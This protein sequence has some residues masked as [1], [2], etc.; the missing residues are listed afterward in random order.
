MIRK[1]LFFLLLCACTPSLHAQIQV[2]LSVK[3]RFFVVYEPIIAT[4]TITN[5][6]GRDVP[7]TDADS[8]HW[9][10]FEIVRG[11]GE[12]IAPI[13]PNY[14]MSPLVIPAGQTVKRSVNLN[15]L[16][17]VHDFGLH[18]IKAAIYFAPMQKYFV[19][20]QVNIELS[21]GKVIWQQ[22]VGVPDGVKGAGGT[23]KMSLL[24]F[25]QDDKNILYV[26]VEDAN[27]GTIYCT[28]PVGALINET[29]PQIQIDFN[30]QLHLL[31]V[32][33]PKT[34]AYS[35][36]GTNGEWL[37]QD[38]YVSTKTR[39]TLRRDGASEVSVVGGELRANAPAGTGPGSATGGTVPKLS[40]RPE[41]GRAHV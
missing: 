22:T 37:G 4:I 25:R 16:F 14:E 23:R 5:R 28:T 33:G 31:Q 15:A 29:Q 32:V 10:G 9:F 17:P 40:D 18:R 21:D 30:N 12:I 39:P 35:R 2:G 8:Q 26:R 1:L 36:I 11:N 13:N 38:I 24:T 34:W 20:P 19:S 41:I 3:R 6:S 7:L 27:D